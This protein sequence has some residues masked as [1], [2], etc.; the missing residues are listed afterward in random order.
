ML[1]HRMNNERK[2]RFQGLWRAMYAG[3]AFGLAAS[4]ASG[5]DTGGQT[6][7]G[8]S[9]SSG[10]STSTSTST[11]SSGST[12]SGNMMVCMPGTME[13]CYSG[14]DGTKG[15][16][17]CT[18][19][20]RTCLGDGSGYTVCVGEVLP[21]DETCDSP[22]DDDCDGS[23]NEINGINCVCQPNLSEACYSGTPGTENVGVC[24]GGMRSC[25]ALGTAWGPCEGEVVPSPEN[26]SNAD[27]DDCNGNICALP[28]W[29]LIFGGALNDVAPA[30]AVDMNGNVIVG[31]TFSGTMTVGAQ[32]L[33]SAGGTD[34]FIAQFDT[35]GNLKWAQSLG[36][37]ADQ[38]VTGVASDASGNVFVTGVFAG[39]LNLGGMGG[40]TYTANG[41]DTF[42]M[43]LGGSGAYFWSKRI[44]VSG[45]QISTSI[46][47]NSVGEVAVAG[48]YTG[49]L[50]CV[51]GCVASLGAQDLF[52]FKYDTNGAQKFYKTF[53][54]AS[55]QVLSDIEWTDA[56][57]LLLTG[58]MKGSAVDFGGGMP[59][60]SAGGYD[61]FAV[62]L[63]TTGTH[64]WS[65]RFGD[66]LDQKG[67]AITSDKAGN[68]V[69]GGSFLGSVNFGA[70][71]I[72]SAGQSDLFIAKLGPD[73]SYMWASGYGDPADQSFSDLTADGA[74]NIFLTAG[75]L[76]SVDFGQGPL[77]S[78]VSYDV[79][80]AK[81]DAQGVY[82]WGKNFGNTVSQI[83][84]AV[85][86]DGEING[87]IN[88]VVLGTASGMVDFGLGP[89]T[90]AGGDDVVL[91]KMTP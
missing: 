52:V 71:D 79:L 4:C 74:G 77:T 56:D 31:G 86:M 11:S 84:R 38:S 62:K 69:L 82:Q 36:D 21:A 44:G 75:L 42:V 59:L 2:T 55:D 60:G 66:P 70:L 64:V 53:G 13:E 23:T 28:L 41:K 65:K 6:G 34:G 37:A 83:G 9:S 29:N 91:L 3:L 7:S 90:A 10:S 54:D 46:A 87:N 12:S 15:I 1:I 35:N 30:M 61:I 76:G 73:G 47:V 22:E 80:I 26:C 32:Q 89:L 8:S 27:D 43:K 14:P 63:T 72:Q 51:F 17:V 85:K 67:V 48:H 45:D 88:I 33:T 68:V 50:I 16:G 20:Q 40:A 25:N 78:A 49:D 5:S 58:Y 24:K 18:S 19:G 81:F 57:E 39:T